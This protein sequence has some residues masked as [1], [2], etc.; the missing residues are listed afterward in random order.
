MNTRSA[1][2]MLS[3]VRSNWQKIPK[4]VD[5]VVGIPRSG[6]IPALYIGLTKNIDVADLE[7]YLNGN[8]LKSGNST[9]HESFCQTK[10]NKYK[11]VLIIDD[12]CHSGKAI[13]QARRRLHSMNPSVNHY[14]MAVYSSNPFNKKIDGYFEH[15]EPPHIFEWNLS[16]NP[17]LTDSLVDID[18]V[19]C[20]NPT[21]SQESSEIN[22][23]AF[24]ETAKPLFQPKKKLKGLVTGRLEKYRHQTEKWLR[25]NNVFYDSLTMYPGLDRKQQS[26]RDVAIFKA[27]IF[28]A[29]SAKLFIESSTEESEIIKIASGK[30]VLCYTGF[31]EPRSAYYLKQNPI[32]AI[33][34]TVFWKVKSYLEDHPENSL[35]KSILLNKARRILKLLRQK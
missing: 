7:G 9:D 2:Q 6:M 28:K 17:I 4:D 13:E 35:V 33:N 1:I 34:R 19:L 5:L 20:E 26:L 27:N 16:R 11:N 25:L 8:V 30:A 14:F 10:I 3:A 31:N 24:I 29:T 12:S 23:L 21:K 32:Y 22:Y 15:L 18:G